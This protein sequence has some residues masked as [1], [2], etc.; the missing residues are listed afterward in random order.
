[1]LK[2]LTTVPLN[3]QEIAVLLIVMLIGMGIFSVS[4]IPTDS[5]PDVSN[6]QVQIIVEPE[7]MATEEIE[8]LVT[9]PIEYALNG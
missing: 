1:M 5:F 2:V 9:V 8:S 4:T 6:T 7:N 3:R